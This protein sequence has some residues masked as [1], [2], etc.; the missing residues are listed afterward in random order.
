MTARTFDTPLRRPR[1]TSSTPCATSRAGSRSSSRVRPRS[2][3]RRAQSAQSARLAP[4]ARLVS[5]GPTAAA[6]SALA[7]PAVARPVVAARPSHVR[8]TRRGRVLLLL[9]LVTLLLV[10]FSLGRTSADAGHGAPASR[11]TTVVQPGETLWSIARRVAP[12]A[13]ARVTVDRLSHLNDL[14]ARPIVAGQ[15]LVLPS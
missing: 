4:E 11:S 7:R 14:G 13:D 2:A 6:R 8:L 1:S 10:A 12:G 15:R 9:T 5:G 3:M